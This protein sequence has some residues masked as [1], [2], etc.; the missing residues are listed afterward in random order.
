MSTRNAQRRTKVGAVY[1]YASTVPWSPY[2]IIIIVI[3][4]YAVMRRAHGLA[5]SRRYAGRA[6]YAKLFYS[7]VFR[8]HYDVF[9]FS[10]TTVNFSHFFHFFR[11]P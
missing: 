6:I 1:R 11:T 5:F 9:F 8:N 3:I 10:P 4:V 2:V 7:F